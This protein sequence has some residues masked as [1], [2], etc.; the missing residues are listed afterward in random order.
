MIWFIRLLITL[1]IVSVIGV[2]IYYNGQQ[3]RIFIVHSYNTDLAWVKEIDKGLD[4]QLANHLPSAQVR[5]HYMDLKN[6]PACNFY[7][8]AAKDTRLAIKSW[9]P[10]ILILVDDLAQQLVGVN[11]LQMIDQPSQSLQHWYQTVA[12]GLIDTTCPDKSNQ[13]SAAELFEFGSDLADSPQRPLIVFAGVNHDVADYGYYDAR[14]T[15]GIFERKNFQAL[16]ETLVDLSAASARYQTDRLLILNEH[17]GTVIHEMNR[18]ADANNW[19]GLV[20]VDAVMVD[21]QQQWQQAVERANREQAMLLIANYQNIYRTE[22]RRDKVP[23]AELVQWTEQQALYPILG[24]GTGYVADG[25]MITLAIAGREQ[26]EQAIVLAKTYLT[27]GQVPPPIEAKQF[28][29]GLNKR[30]MQLKQIQLPSIYEAF[31]ETVK[32]FLPL[33]E[34]VY[35]R[36][37]DS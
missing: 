13:P 36:P 16:A 18:Y 32:P 35:I 34:I 10:D 8:V 30:L 7:R 26:G 15:T 29:I 21:T 27:Q 4:I 1:L 22:E 3:P 19:P 11:Y 2:I 9:Q 20:L 25:G 33:S 28:L 31:S 14:N 6:H 12:Q 24:A 23:A 17:S 5:R 37:E